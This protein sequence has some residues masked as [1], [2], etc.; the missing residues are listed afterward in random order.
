MGKQ[1]MPKLFDEKPKLNDVSGTV[2][3]LDSYD[4]KLKATPNNVTVSSKADKP[5]KD[6]TGAV[7]PKEAMGKQRVPSKDMGK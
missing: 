6:N 5:S 7:K 2:T 3:T 1:K 4:A